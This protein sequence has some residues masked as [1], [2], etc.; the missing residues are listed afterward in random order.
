M[1]WLLNI[2][3]ALLCAGVLVGCVC[4]VTILRPAVGTLLPA[5]SYITLAAFAFGVGLDF[6]R[7]RE[8]EWYVTFGLVTAVLHFYRTQRS[9]LNCDDFSQGAPQ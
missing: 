1:E 5:G 4:R 7:S 6:L 2:V 8:V 9:W 3:G